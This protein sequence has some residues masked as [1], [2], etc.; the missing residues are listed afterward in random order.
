MLSRQDERR[1]PPHDGNCNS[2][3]K[4]RNSIRSLR[5][6]FRYLRSTISTESRLYTLHQTAW[7]P[8]YCEHGAILLSPLPV[9]V[10]NSPST[11]SAA[12]MVRHDVG[13]EV[14]YGIGYHTDRG[15]LDAVL[16]RR[17][18]GSRCSRN[19]LG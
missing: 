16:Q 1:S 10:L 11:C 19:P 15:L 2:N 4:N 17:R 9:C 3:E 6:M 8:L 5:N 13:R 7:R 18:R 12:V 14:I